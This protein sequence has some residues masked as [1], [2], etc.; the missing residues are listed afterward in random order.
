ACA[1]S[2]R[3]ATHTGAC[4]SS[5]EARREERR[6]PQDDGG[7]W[8]ESIRRAAKLRCRLGFR[9]RF[10]R[11]D[12]GA[13]DPRCLD[14][15]R[16]FGARCIGGPGRL[17]R[18]Q[19]ARPRYRARH[20]HVADALMPEIA[21]GESHARHRAAK[22]AFGVLDQI[23]ARLERKTPERGADGLAAHLKRIAW[24]ADMAHRAGARELDRAGGTA[25]IENPACATRAI[26]AGECEHL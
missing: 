11:L 10:D 26:E 9:F 12:P 24:K 20:Q 16:Y 15:R 25:V 14:A 13:L 23:E 4:C 17:R 19:R 6:A 22:A 7:V 18:M 3:M 2:R 21:I 1:A 8:R 5:F